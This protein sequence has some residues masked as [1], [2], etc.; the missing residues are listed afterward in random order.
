M[1]KVA[2]ILILGAAISG[3]SGPP[4][5]EEQVRTYLDALSDGDS[6]RMAGVF[7]HEV[8]D[9][10]SLVI[11]PEVSID[12]LDVEKVSETGDTAEVIAEY[13]ADF[14]GPGHTRV[15]FTLTRIDGEWLISNAEAV[16]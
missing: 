13:D 2:L 10:M 11:L 4:G 6:V 12:N 8:R 15:K 16:E 3:C 9:A 5:P 7:T 14:P 1:L